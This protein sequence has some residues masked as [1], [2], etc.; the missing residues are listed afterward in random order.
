MSRRIGGLTVLAVG[1]LL[2]AAAAVRA[3][4]DRRAFRVLPDQKVHVESWFV[5]PGHP[6]EP[7]KGADVTVTG[8]EGEVAKGKTDSEGVFVFAFPRFEPLEVTIADGRG[9]GGTLKIS[10]D[11][12]RKP[13]TDTRPLRSLQPPEE[14]SR[15]G[16]EEAASPYPIR[17]VILGVTFLLAVAAF[18]ISLRNA[19]AIKRM[20]AG[21]PPGQDL[22]S[23]RSSTQQPRG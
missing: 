21:V 23:S 13:S 16:G 6:N 10:A 5:A 2:A 17:E 15:S 3:H 1:V 22:P 8:P 7:M 14:R 18:V 9:H 19:Q 12:L 20:Q 4:D 11:D